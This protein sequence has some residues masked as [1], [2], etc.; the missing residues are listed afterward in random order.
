[1]RYRSHQTA[2][3]AVAMLVGL[4]ASAHAHALAW[5]P[6]TYKLKSGK[7]V[8]AQLGR[9]AVPLHRD[10][11]DSKTI[12]L[13]L[14][15][16][17]ATG[18][19][20][21][22]PI[23][24]LAGGPGSS[25]IAA[26]RGKRWALFNA[27]RKAGDV[28]LL[29]QRGTGLSSPPPKCSQ[30]WSFPG[31]QAST[32]T[33]FNVSL[34]AAARR[35]AKEWRTKGV[36]LSAYN[37]AENAADVADLV[38]ALGGHANLVA[39]SY[40]TFLAFA[41]LRDHDA[42]IDRVVLAGTEGPDDTIKLPT[43]AD[44]A[45][46]R[47]SRLVARDPNASK[48]TPDLERSVRTVFARLG[49]APVRVDLGKG[50]HQLTISQYDMQMVTAFLMSSSENA[51][52]LPKLFATM[53]HGNFKLAARMV[54]W[55]RRFFAT[56]PAMPLATDAASPTSPLRARK[57]R[58]LARTSLFGNAVNAPSADFARALRVPKMAARWRMPIHSTTPAYFISGDLDSR[59][60][61]R[62]AEHVRRGFA[63]S[64]HL[65]LHG[66]GHD[67]DLFLSS[68]RIAQRI[69]FFLRGD[70]VTDEV[71]RVHALHFR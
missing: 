57:A 32:E 36:D 30:R 26:G 62:N 48:L 13:H 50:G 9:L 43:Q 45:L 52:R 34:E 37:T 11:P 38:Q 19:G 31:Y 22:A 47:L 61:P 2:A 4:A 17:R 25:G 55:L 63:Q 67:D 44:V 8:Q 5:S 33:S 66:A 42:L 60:P 51:V 71:W 41:V 23:I 53:E 49:R 68:P 21:G 69:A 28:I 14:V 7:T 3:L 56:L 6:Y 64:A 10:R 35:C 18:T 70:P 58:A 54:L 1:M 59:T 40:G 24:Y 46:K 39:I 20:N 15:R 65:V 29:D 12:D 16:F 27:L